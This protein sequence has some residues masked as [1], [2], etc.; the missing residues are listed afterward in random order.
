[1]KILLTF[2]LSFLMSGFFDGQTEDA[3]PSPEERSAYEALCDI[4]YPYGDENRPCYPYNFGGAKQEDE[5]L[6][7]Y[8]Y[9]KR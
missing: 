4:I 3:L 5:L 6:T 1:M 2:I 9:N 8:I 7:I